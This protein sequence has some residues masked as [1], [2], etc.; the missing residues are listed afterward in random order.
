VVNVEIEKYQCSE[1]G[2]T[3]YKNAF[4]EYQKRFHRTPRCP[5]GCFGIIW[6]EIIVVD[7]LR[8]CSLMDENG[9]CTHRKNLFESKCGLEDQTEC[10][11]YK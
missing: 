5:N 4:D 2:A 6:K 3:L 8:N 9:I 11:W 1:C 10:V 7:N